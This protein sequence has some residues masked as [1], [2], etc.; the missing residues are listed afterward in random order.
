M[1]WVRSSSSPPIASDSPFRRGYFP[2]VLGTV[3]EMPYIVAALR[4]G[5]AERNSGTAD[6]ANWQD[7]P[8]DLTHSAT[9]LQVATV[10]L[11]RIDTRSM[12]HSVAAFATSFLAEAVLL[13]AEGTC[14]L[15]TIADT[16]SSPFRKAPT[17]SM[18][19]SNA[20]D[21]SQWGCRAYEF[22]HQDPQASFKM[23]CSSAESAV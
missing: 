7:S 2:G 23:R 8:S 1:C 11:L 4:L 21:R 6:T 5:T 16:S 14:P 9:T 18:P 22:C 3:V 13:T 17:G 10:R 19:G 15:V 20:W 12:L